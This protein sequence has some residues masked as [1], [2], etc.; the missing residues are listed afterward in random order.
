M[1]PEAGIF[2]VIDGVGGYAAGEVAAAMACQIIGQCLQEATDPS[3]E[4]LRKAITTANNEIFQRSQD[5]EAVRDMACVLTA[6]VIQGGLVNYGHVGDTR[7][8]EIRHAGINKIT[9]DHSV[10]GLRE[11]AGELTEEE[12]MAHERRHEILR[13]VGSSYRHIDDEPFVDIDEFSFAPDSALLLCSDGLTDAVP[14]HLIHE[15]VT[16]HAGAPEESVSA[17]I[18]LARER[19]GRD[20][21]TVI[22]V[23]GTAFASSPRVWPSGGQDTAPPSFDAEA[24]P[25]PDTLGQRLFLFGGGVLAGFLTALLLYFFI[26]YWH[27]HW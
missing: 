21:I 3:E 24:A 6:V 18:E 15:T 13:D 12:A 26:P 4:R 8:Y 22:V 10:V 23:E 2:V 27:T 16:A 7:L 1:D 25:V 14:N 5:D 9:K 19:G 20:D 17:L 11:D